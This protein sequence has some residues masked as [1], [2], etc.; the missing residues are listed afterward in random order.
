MDVDSAQR[1]FADIPVITRVEDSEGT[2]IPNNGATQNT[3]LTL[4][5]TGLS[6]FVL[7][8]LDNGVSV[9]TVS[10]TSAG[11]WEISVSAE[12]GVHSYTARQ[13][14]GAISQPWVI[15]V[16]AVT[17]ELPAPTIIGTPEGGVLDP[18]VVVQG[19][20]VT[21]H[22][23]TMVASDHIRVAWFGKPFI[24]ETEGS[25]SK[26]INVTM[27]NSAVAASLGQPVVLRYGVTHVGAGSELPSDPLQFSVGTLAEGGLSRPV[28]KQANANGVLELKT[29]AGDATVQV[30]PW[31]LIADGQTVWLSVAGPGGVPT[32]ELLAA[33]PISVAEAANGI[34][35]PLARAELKKIGNGAALTVTCKVG[36]VGQGDEAS[37]INLPVANYRINTLE[38]VS[39]S[40][41]WQSYP[42]ETFPFNTVI[43]WPTGLS[44]TV[45][46]L[47]GTANPASIPVLGKGFFSGSPVLITMAFVGVIRQIIVEYGACQ[48]NR[49]YIEA[50]DENNVV[51]TRYYFPVT[52][53]S[54]TKAIEMVRPCMSIKIYVD[55]GNFQD[56]G[57]YIHRLTWN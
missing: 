26:T 33:Y 35:R 21:V 41:N 5:G 7:V 51:L 38:Y 24:V 36:F 14:G 27:P 2:F 46:R 55:E 30:P 29:F 50:F 16:A 45:A 49:N 22:Y 48:G 42:A 34:E 32:L 54:A 15:T 8:I 6:G 52:P 44:A 57:M 17:E 47:S 11:T 9:G 53:G 25:N 18:N 19:V 43:A 12:L 31:R 4:S 20:E 37:S 40:E 1:S 13:M 3:A 28:I 10:V 56:G 23:E 39:G